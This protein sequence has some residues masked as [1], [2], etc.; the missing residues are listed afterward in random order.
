MKFFYHQWLNVVRGGFGCCENS[1]LI[2]PSS[3][4]RAKGLEK[5]PGKTVHRQRHD[6]ARAW[7]VPYEGGAGIE[8]TRRAPPSPPW[9]QPA[10]SAAH[11]QSRNTLAKW[12]G[13]A[14]PAHTTATLSSPFLWAVSPTLDSGHCSLLVL[15][16]LL[17]RCFLFS[18]TGLEL[19]P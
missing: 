2:M 19:F 4:W 11:G 17:W 16:L 6:G 15:L 5:V 18:L 12:G 1:F 3:S 8:A 7:A 13:S 10:V 9:G 14:G